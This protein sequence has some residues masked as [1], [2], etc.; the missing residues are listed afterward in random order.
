MNPRRTKALLLSGAVYVVANLAGLLYCPPIG[1]LLIVLAAR[2][3]VI[4]RR[5]RLPT[6]GTLAQER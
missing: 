3:I 4:A 1:F 2:E 5:Y 6:S